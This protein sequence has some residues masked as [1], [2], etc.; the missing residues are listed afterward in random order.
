MSVSIQLHPLVVL[1]VSD[2]LTR[3]KYLSDRS[4]QD[5]LRVFGALLGKQVGRVLEIVNTVEVALKSNL[6]DQGAVIIDTQFM[7]A[8]LDSYKKNFPELDCIGWYSADFKNHDQPISGIDN[9]V[10]KTIHQFSENPL[11]LIM[12]PDSKEAS[13]KKTLPYFLYDYESQNQKF[14]RLDYQ[15]ATE[16]SERIAVDH[17]A[18]AVD[19]NAKTSVLSQNMQSSINAVKIFRRKIKFLIDIVRNSQEVRKNHEFMRK[20]NQIVSQLPITTRESFNGNA[21]N[22]YS[23][24]AAVNLLASVTKGFELLNELLDNFKLYQGR[25]GYNMSEMMDGNFGLGG[26]G[27][28]GNPMMDEEGLA[29]MAMYQQ[30]NMGKMKNKFM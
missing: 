26:R 10:H 7:Q 3:A 21:F 18:K 17:I 29:M 8:R 19:P 4:Q 28:G 16:D 11:Y 1:N 14:V 25:D 9:A 5:S 30:T 24:I 13:E 23:D 20:L 15:L 6:Q 2:H 22:E 27:S 12:N